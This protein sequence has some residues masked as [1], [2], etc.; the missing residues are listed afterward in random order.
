MSA[1]RSRKAPLKL[2]TEAASAPPTKYKVDFLSS[3]TVYK[4]AAGQRVPGVTT[5]LN[6]LNK[7]ALLPWAWKLGKEG[8]D[9]EAARRKPADTGTVAHALC[10]AHLRGLE[11]DSENIAPDILGRA[12]TSFLKFVSW[13]DREDLMMVHTELEMVSE[14][15]QVG[16]R[17]DILAVRKAGQFVL[18]DLKSSKAIY[19]EMLLQAA[20]YAAMYEEVQGQAI[21]EVK[22]VRI[23]KEDADDLEVRDVNNRQARVQAFRAL[24]DARRHLQAI[25]MRV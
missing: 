4:N 23:G 17:L 8:I 24:V 7:P 9:L 3:H 13:W 21:A 5:V 6:M 18:V 14:Q 1:D 22:I 10:E 12:E 19:D 11:L 16:G 25:G 15:M 20:T 2:A